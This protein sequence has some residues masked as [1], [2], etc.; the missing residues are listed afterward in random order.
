MDLSDAAVSVEMFYRRI[1][2]QAPS[3]ITYNTP[4]YTLTYSGTPW[5]H[6][7]NQL[8]LHNPHALNRGLLEAAAAFFKSYRA[9]YSIVFTEP[10]PLERAQWLT[11]SHYS[12]RAS[13]PIFGLR[14]LPRPHY[15]H[16]EA[17]IIQATA[18]HQTELLNILYGTFFM[19]PEIGRYAVRTEHFT[20]S[21]IRHYLAYVG[22]EV[23]A[24]ATVLLNDHIAGIWNVGTL[25]PFRRQGV[26]SA[27]L[28]RVLTDAAAEGC[29]NSVLVASTMGRPLYEEMDYRFLGNTLFYGLSN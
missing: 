25:R 6:S 15:L 23:A 28:M 12:E 1:Y 11:D 13:N 3:A 9:E 26:A 5:L 21:M 20:D 7:I 10:E 27:L 14:G 2:W 22:N 29:P 4:D 17:E 18:Q 24:C 16:R 19:G 8:W